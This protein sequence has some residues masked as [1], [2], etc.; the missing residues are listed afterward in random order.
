MIQLV[1]PAAGRGQRF[2]DAGYTE[3]KPDIPVLGKPMIQRVIENLRPNGSCSVQIIREV[4]T[5]GA[6]ETIL[7]AEIDNRPLL[8]GNCDQLVAFDVNDFIAQSAKDGSLVTFKSNKPHHSY[9]TL[10][11]GIISTIVEK[12]VIS[13]IAVTGVYYFKDGEQFK[14]A[15]KKII[16]KDIKTNGEFY[17]SSVIAELIDSGAEINTYEAPSAML[18]TPE[19]LQLFEAAVAVGKTL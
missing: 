12:E 1:I 14:Q 15:A 19:E 11:G 5:R 16:H 9:V 2:K 4:E 17:V 8:I 18:G 6:V 13:N 10:D 3:L 7:C